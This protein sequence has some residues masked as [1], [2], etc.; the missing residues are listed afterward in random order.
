[1][2]VL[3]AFQF[4]GRAV[5]FVVASLVALLVAGGT[6]AFAFWYSGDQDQV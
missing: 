1:M 6:V 2:D 5:W 3:T 4:D